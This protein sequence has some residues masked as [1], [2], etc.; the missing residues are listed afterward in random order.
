MTL[1]ARCSDCLLLELLQI[2][3]ARG[4]EIKQ[5][6]GRARSNG[7]FSA[8]DCTS[9]NRPSPVMTTFTSTSAFESSE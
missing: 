2:L 8:V 4:G 6:V 5:L 1:I 7:T 9:T 3:D